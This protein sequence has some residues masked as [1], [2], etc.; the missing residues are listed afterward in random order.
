VLVD[1][2]AASG[3][4]YIYIATGSGHGVRRSTDEGATWTPVGLDGHDIQ[5]T[6]MALSVDKRSIFVTS[7]LGSYRIDG[8]RGGT[9]TTTRLGGPTRC[10][11]IAEIGGT[12]YAA[13][14]TS[15]VFRVTGGGATWTRLG[16]T[17]LSTASAWSAIGGAGST[18][19]VGC[20]FPQPGQSVAKST[21]GG[22]TWTFVTAPSAISTQ[23]WGANTSWWLAQAEP[24]IVLGDG[25][26]EVTQIALDA[27]DPQ[28]VYLAGRSGAWKSEDGGAHWRPA[29]NH[30]GGTMHNH[31][32]ALTGGGARTDDVD[33]TEET[34]SDYFASV[35]KGSATFSKAPTLDLEK[36]GHHYVVT[37]STPRDFL[38][39]GVSIA[40]SYF[41]AAA[42]RAA[43][44][45]VSSDGSHIY[46]AQFGGG[47]LVA[48]R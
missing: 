5:M 31:V 48:H 9:A 24:R 39:D 46:V 21:D 33:W 26:S 41:R 47:V 35:T 44:I 22:D 16:A 18:I 34:T 42:V 23:I 3:V 20:A 25:T 30:L 38:L 19:Y 43:D 13:C 2:D 28:V 4:E 7:H 37:S 40:D 45:D 1:Y 29:V 8:V 36:N 14:N 10:E 12:L 27:F 32:Q 17:K 15:G 6:G 11:E